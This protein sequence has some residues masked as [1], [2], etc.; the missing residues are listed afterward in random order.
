EPMATK[1]HVVGRNPVV[2]RC[3]YC[4]HTIEGAKAQIL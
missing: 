4:N 3:H 1:F 2:I